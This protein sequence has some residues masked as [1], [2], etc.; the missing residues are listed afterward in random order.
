VPAGPGRRPD[1]EAELAQL[2]HPDFTAA[3]VLAQHSGVWVVS[4]ADGSQTRLAPAR[5]RLRSDDGG[6][7]VTGDWVA[8][9]AAGAIAAV[10]PRHGTIMRRAAGSA[11]RPQ[12]L[13]ANVDLA[14]ITEPL[15]EPN[16][17]RAERLAALASAGGV[18]AAVVLTK[19][20]LADDA[21]AQAARLAGRLGLTEAVAVSCA[22]PDP[23]G[24]GVLRALLV[25]GTTAVLLGPSGSGKSTLVNALL[26][27]DRQATGHV[28]AADAR[29][30][31]TTVTRDLVELPG[32]ALLIDTPGIREA[33]LW[34]GAGDSFAD[35]DALAAECRFA[36]CAHSGDPGCAVAEQLDPD[37]LAAWHKLQSEQAWVDDRR[38]AS[39]EQQREQRGRAMRRAYRRDGE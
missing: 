7:P 34:D 22:G 16:D 19:A 11:S 24:L 21:G 23:S 30:R 5:G 12:V 31:H 35:V 2:G 25:P 8:V 32:G 36:N 27:T 15:P 10:L 33:G 29:G 9:D 17:R 1:L 38:A 14:L 6:Q 26:G 18:P 20:D 28:R 13:A 4:T 3:R 37:R 39:R